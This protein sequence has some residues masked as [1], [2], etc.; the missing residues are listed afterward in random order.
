MASV[1]ERKLDHIVSQI[2]SFQQRKIE[3]EQLQNSGYN[4][5]T[6][7]SINSLMENSI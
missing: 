5:D 7:L 4:F 3:N 1:Q 6:L 2:N